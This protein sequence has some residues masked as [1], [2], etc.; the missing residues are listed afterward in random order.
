MAGVDVDVTLMPARRTGSPGLLLDR[1]P[2]RDAL[3][4]LHPVAARVLRR[5]DRELGA[6]SPG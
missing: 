3:H 2:H 4:D 6:R 1:D 5:Q